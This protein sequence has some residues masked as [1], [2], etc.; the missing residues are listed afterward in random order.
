MLNEASNAKYSPVTTRDEQRSIATAAAKKKDILDDDGYANKVKLFLTSASSAKS[1]KI[2]SPKKY[3]YACTTLLILGFI[4]SLLLTIF[5]WF[6]DLYTSE[7]YKRLTIENGSLLYDA[8]REPPVRPLMCVYIFNYTNFAE[9]VANDGS[10]NIKLK[11][12]EV[13]P[14]CYRETSYRVNITD[15]KNG[16]QTFNEMKIQEFDYNSSNGSDSDIIVVPDI[17]YIIA[18][19]LTK[20]ENFFIRKSVSSYLD[21][22]SEYPFVVVSVYD[23]CFGYQNDMTNAINTLAKIGN[24]TPPFEKFG[25]FVKRVG[26]NQDR[27][28]VFNGHD[29]LNQMGQLMQLNGKS[30]L[31][32]WKT[33]ECNTVGGSDGMFFP[34]YEVQNGQNVNLFHKESCRKLPMTFRSR[35]KIKN[36]IIGHLYTLAHD[37]FNNSIPENSC[38]NVGASPMPDGVFDM[39]AC[40]SNS[41]LLVSRAHFLYSNPSLL[42]AIEGLNPDPKK[43][44]FL[45]IIDPLIGITIE[46]EMRIQLNVQVRNPNNYG[47]LSKIPDNTILPFT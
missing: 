8:W 21:N 33:D 46:T 18:I 24:K 20:D 29:N 2:T 39:G 23:F 9:F 11:V 1:S 32:P 15:H 4:L 31:H 13:G 36:G 6:T 12:Q 7:L 35:K 40:S 17:P 10:N 16:S 43:H 26:V 37:A 22:A 30:L 42:N 25:L 19:A 34:R 3:K 5:I 45:W 44:E 41:P 14:Y 47:T 27:L 28:T 38:Y